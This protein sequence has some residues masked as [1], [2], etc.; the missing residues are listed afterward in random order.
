ML[1][2]T[3][4]GGM[5]QQRS[6]PA[7]LGVTHAWAPEWVEEEKGGQR[8]RRV[9]RISVALASGVPG[10]GISTSYPILSFLTAITSLNRN[11]SID[12]KGK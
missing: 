6:D 11:P 1:D 7:E 12:H 5:E 3:A 2:D 9:D 4:G 10:T 8:P